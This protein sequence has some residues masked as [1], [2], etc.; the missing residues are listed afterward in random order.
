LD[1]F[2]FD[3]ARLTALAAAQAAAYQSATPFPHVVIDDF[4]PDDVIARIIEEFPGP[5]DVDWQR[6]DA[7][8]EVKLATDDIQVVPPYTRHVLDQFN[9]ETMVDFLEQLTGISGLIP[10][11]HFWGGGLHQIER[12]G[13]LKV[14]SDFNWHEE[15]LLD[16]RLNLIVYLNEDWDPAWG[17]GLELWDRDMTACQERVVPVAN[18][19]VIF[20]T[21][22]FSLHGHPDPLDCPP[23]RTRRSMAL[24][25]YSNGRPAEELSTSRSTD[26]RPR[27]GETWRRQPGTGSR[28]AQ[29]IPPALVPVAKKA[30]DRVKAL[31]P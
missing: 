16:R 23:E 11:P 20:N 9:S 3:E 6:F 28:Y 14:H 5:K 24:Y 29:W 4:L 10:D 22:D 1:L 18:R 17:G 31:K 26:F 13:H 25:Y 30:R 2:F 15:L 27:P 12:G 7:D 19:C 21:T 8:T